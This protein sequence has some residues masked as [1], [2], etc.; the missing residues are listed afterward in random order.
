MHLSRSRL[1]LE[2][3]GIHRMRKA[4]SALQDFSDNDLVQFFLRPQIII[5]TL[6]G[7]L[8]F[9]GFEIFDSTITSHKFKYAVLVLDVTFSIIWTGLWSVG[10]C[11][12]AHQWNRST[13]HYLLGGSAARASIT[14]AFF[15]IPCWVYLAC[16]ALKN[17][18]AEP[19][20]PYKRSLDEGSVA[21]TTLSSSTA[22]SF[23][24][25]VG[26]PEN[27]GAASYPPTP[28]PNRLTLMNTDA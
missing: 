26:Y 4:V 1:V 9:L 28:V 3:E 13:H 20:I 23:P 15:S 25:N 6:A 27:V 17:L 10:F 19:P 18:W 2:T 12:L 22:T 14:F 24:N 16:L 21:L 8:L 5:R 11:F 7:S